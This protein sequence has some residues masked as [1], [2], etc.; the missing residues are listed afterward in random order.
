M[1]PIPEDVPETH[2]PARAGI[3]AALGARVQARLV[4]TVQCMDWLSL[5]R[6]LPDASADLILTDPPYGIL[7]FEWDSLLDIPSLMAE[8]MRIVKPTGGGA[9]I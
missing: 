4:D 5:A 9:G 8:L 3:V 7:K 2:T 1:Y 6:L